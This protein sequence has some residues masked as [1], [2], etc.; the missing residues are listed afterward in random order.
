MLADGLV[1]FKAW[2]ESA[3][4]E[5]LPRRWNRCLILLASP[6]RAAWMRGVFGPMIDFL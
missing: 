1:I 4:F 5:V 6:K 2:N 3:G